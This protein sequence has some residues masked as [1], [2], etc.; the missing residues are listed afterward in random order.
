MISQKS[1]WST[2]GYIVRFIYF[3]EVSCSFWVCSRNN[4]IMSVLFISVK[5]GLHH[6]QMVKSLK[7]EDKHHL[8]SHSLSFS[9]VFS[10]FLSLSADHLPVFLHTA[11]I[12]A[13]S[14]WHPDISHLNPVISFPSFRHLSE[15]ECEAREMQ[16]RRPPLSWCC[17]GGSPEA[18][19]VS[20]QNF[21]NSLYL[22][23]FFFIYFF[24]ILCHSE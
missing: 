3:I 23:N 8:F 7:R 21:I 14:Q 9:C 11:A 16:P 15:S 6:N 10:L 22:F 20:I 19:I 18:F 13:V 1:T 12:C 5:C 2:L 24:F 17:I 4:S